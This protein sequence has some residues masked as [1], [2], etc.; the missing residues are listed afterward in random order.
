MSLAVSDRLQINEVIALHGHLCDAGAYERF[1][2]VFTPDLEVDV[3]DLGLRPVPTGDPSRSRLEA[4]TA[5]ARDR[6]P[7]SQG[8]RIR[9]R[10]VSPRREPGH[11]VEPRTTPR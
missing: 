4:Y 6:G 1:G 2:E 8:R 3:S 11:G 9:R 5:V 10:K 7:A